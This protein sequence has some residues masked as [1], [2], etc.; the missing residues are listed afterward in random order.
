M[1]PYLVKTPKIFYTL[2]YKRIWSLSNKKNAV[3]LTFDDGPIPEITPWILSQLKKYQA[4]ATFFCVG[5]NMVKHPELSKNM[6]Q[7]GHTL[8]N[9]TFN[10][11]NGWKT[12]AAF[13]IENVARTQG[14]IHT[15]SNPVNKSKIFR[16][17]YG[18]LTPNQAALL[19]K[20][21]YKIIMWSVLSADFDPN[22]SKEICLKNVLKN[23]VPGS[24]IVFH[25]SLKTKEK[26]NYVLPKVL[27]YI[28]DKNWHCE[29]I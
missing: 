10:H 21:G 18:K 28:Y 4:K 13:Y 11:L 9:H 1:K 5:E 23:I 27:A 15:I 24:I 14:L 17:P 8:G 19:L 25:D 3:F 22:I 26:L 12:N 16:P 2:F 29:A 20:N 7:E 6:V